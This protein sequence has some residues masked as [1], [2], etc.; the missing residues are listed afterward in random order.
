MLAIAFSAGGRLVATMSDDRTAPGGTRRSA[1]QCRPA[2]IVRM[3]T[4]LRGRG[5]TTLGQAQDAARRIYRARVSTLSRRATDRP[6]DLG[7]LKAVSRGRV[8]RSAEQRATALRYRT[9]P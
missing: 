7:S 6:L 3:L 5:I 8:G 9:A 4:L 1:P 2:R